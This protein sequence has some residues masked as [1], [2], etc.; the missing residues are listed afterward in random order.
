[1]GTNKII[2]IPKDYF[3]YEEGN[4]PKDSFFI[5]IKGKV[6]AYSIGSKNFNEEY[7][8][9]VI[10]GLF[11]LLTNEPYFMTMQTMDYTELLE[12]KL[13]DIDNLTNNDL[14]NKIYFY[15]KN[16]LETWL[17]RYY[18][19]LAKNKLDLY[20]KENMFTMANIYNQNNLYGISYKLYREYIRD[21]SQEAD[22]EKAKIELK[23][24]PA[25]IEPKIFT[26]NIVLYKKGSCIYTEVNPTNQ[27]YIIIHGKIGIYNII[28]GNLLLRDIYNKNYILDGYIPKLEYKPLFTSA[29]A[30]EDSYV[31]KMYIED[32]IYM[33]IKNRGLRLHNIKM[34]SA[35]IINAILKI[36]AIEEKDFNLK[37]FIII[38]AI[39]KSEILFEE[40]DTITLSCNIYDIKNFIN[41]PIDHL[42]K[43]MQNIKSLELINNKYIKILN[44]DNFFDE[45]YE[46]KK[47]NY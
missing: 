4:Y 29:V 24:L 32:F 21:F 46:Y 47:K 41:I 40:Y 36:K 45:Y 2:K 12:L 35:K 18:I 39:I 20:Y 14:I 3:L 27:L 15:F 5:I 23:K 16:T 34:M 42:K 44:I 6:K 19:L 13:Y 26:N 9:G 17:S 1:M 25:Y 37:I 10:I 7:N 43:V 33:M 31:K 28:N 22:I 8:E 38:S 30:L 11:N